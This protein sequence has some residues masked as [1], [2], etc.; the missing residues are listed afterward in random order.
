[1]KKVLLLIMMFSLAI[2]AEIS[3]GLN[4]K[5]SF[6]S[7][8]TKANGT[9]NGN[10]E[11]HLTI[12]PVFSIP[13]SRNAN[14]EPSAGL[15]WE[16]NSSKNSGNENS[17]SQGGL[18][19]SCGI[20]FEII[21]NNVVQIAL[22]PDGYYNVWFVPTIKSKANANSA[23]QDISPNKYSRNGFGI[24]APLQVKF[25]INQTWSV[26]IEGNLFELGWDITSSDG[27]D[28]NAF[29]YSLQSILSPSVTMF[30]TF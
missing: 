30:V 29:N 19:F 23:E 10:S 4:L 20:F 27:V 5:N 8:S 11:F 2:Q 26:R 25:P 17:S 16:S 15:L 3:L 28:S 1:M 14:L 18:F 7:T 6:G 9:E 24:T 21:E 22:G 13:I 12:G